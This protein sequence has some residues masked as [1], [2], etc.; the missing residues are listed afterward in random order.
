[1]VTFLSKTEAAKVQLLRYLASNELSAP[2]T[3]LAEHF[4]LSSRTI[5]RHFDDLKKDCLS[6]SLGDDLDF[7]K[8]AGVFSIHLTGSTPMNFLVD[9][10]RLNYI[11]NS[12]E[13][14]ILNRLLNRKYDNIQ[15]LADELYLSPPNLY[16][17]LYTL[18]PIIEKFDMSFSFIDNPSDLNLIYKERRL[19]LFTYYFYWNFYKGLE[20]PKPLKGVAT[21]SKSE[22]QFFGDELLPTKQAQILYMA[23]ISRTRIEQ[24]KFITMNEE[25]SLIAE[26]FIR[27]NDLSQEFSFFDE[28]AL[29]QDM[30]NERYYF[31]FMMRLKI[32]DLDNEEQKHEIVKELLKLKTPLAVES[33]E[34]VEKSL[35]HFGAVLSKKNL[36][37]FYY[38]S[39]IFFV[40]ANYFNIDLPEEFGVLRKANVYDIG[41]E[42]TG[43]VKRVSDFYQEFNADH[44]V[45]KEYDEMLKGVISFSLHEKEQKE[46]TIAM[47]LSKNIMAEPL[48][49]EKL[50]NIFNPNVLKFTQNASEADIIVSDSYEGTFP[51]KSYFYMSDLEDGAQLKQLFHFIENALFV[52]EFSPH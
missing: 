41:H 43:L 37:Q 44:H 23:G 45:P 27:V 52:K 48:V 2:V 4:G 50:G 46:L 17:Y 15:E 9:Y 51:S 22:S 36:D 32:P 11:R 12:V 29:Q 39:T 5:T 16:R 19:R 42:N 33:R 24:G 26:T 6:L 20:V 47:Q 18:E 35:A 30:T 31:N 38:H 49:K 21:T 7:D 13:F 28:I 40:Y 10:L 14:D 34:L 8:K 3:E 1:M 25:I